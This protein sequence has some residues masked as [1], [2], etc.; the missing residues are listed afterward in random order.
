MSHQRLSQSETKLIQEA[1]KAD[2]RNVGIRLRE[3]EY[4]YDLV[5][6]IAFF[7]LKLQLPDVKDIINHLYGDEKAVD[8]QFVRKIQT[9]LKKMEKSNVIGILPKR[10]PWELQKY[11]LLSFKFQDSDKNLSVF[12]TDHEIQQ[13]QSM[14]HVVL[15]KQSMNRINYFELFMMAFATITLYMAI[16]WSLIQPLIALGIFVPALLGSVSCSLIVGK[17]LSQRRL[18]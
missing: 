17:M 11:M 4:Q 6:S 1:L 14:L 5:K 3:G 13:T 7:Q 10:K 2:S 18:H 9:V 12:A 15:K 8:L 16:L